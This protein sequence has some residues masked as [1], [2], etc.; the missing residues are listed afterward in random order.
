MP[1]KL[2]VETKRLKKYFPITGGVFKRKIGD[3]KAVDGVDLG[4]LEGECLSLVGESGCG[5]TTL[6]KTVTRLLRPTDGHIF[7]DVPEK[8]KDKIESLEK[9]E[10]PNSKK[11]LKLEKKYDL[12]KY[13]EGRLKRMR[14]DI[15][16]VFQDP[17]SSLNPRMLMKDI[18]GEPLSVHG[19]GGE[20]ARKRMLEIIRKV[21]LTKDQLYRYPHEFS[22][23][24]R[25]RIAIARA[26][27]LSPRFVVLDEPTS[28]LDLSVQ[29]HILN[30]L[31]KLQRDLGLTYLFITH[32]L[33]LVEYFCDRVAVMYVG[34]IVEQAPRKKLFD[35]PAHPYTQALL[36][37]V[38]VPDPAS[39]SKLI[40]LR[41]KVPDPANPPPGCRFHPR[42]PR[43]SPVCAKKYPELVDVGGK[44]Y[45]ACWHPGA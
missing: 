3:V 11:L 36:S 28:A 1:V 17:F 24:Q 21:G 5:K 2:L 13:D 20:S 26:L 38:P 27:V 8:I 10:G 30:L 25:Q 16:I 34:K 19:F 42:C 6:G 32:N 22:G 35:D 33:S 31:Q 45:V 37:S 29:A 15:Q 7:Y 4:I 41:G 40:P 9:L 39:K 18:V 44:H 12:A 14:R 23:G 43:A